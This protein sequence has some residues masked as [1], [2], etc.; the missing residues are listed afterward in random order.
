MKISK[1]S[2]GNDPEGGTGDGSGG[3]KKH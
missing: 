3:G 2:G 1:M